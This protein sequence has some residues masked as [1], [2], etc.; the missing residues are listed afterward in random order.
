MN[1]SAGFASPRGMV[2]DGPA[3]GGRLVVSGITAGYGG[4]DALRDVSVEVA[5]GEAVGLLGA[6]GAGKTTLLRA[7]SGEVGVRRGHIEFDGRSTRSLPPNRT[8][9]LGIAHVLQGRHVFPDM[10]VR[11]NL[12]L[13]AVARGRRERSETLEIL[14][15][16][17]PVLAEAAS[18]R[19]GN[20]SGGQQ[21]MLVIG[22]AVMS[23][24]R[25]LLLDEPSLGLA[26]VMF[27]A[28]VAI[29]EWVRNTLGSSILLVEQNSSLALSI[30]SRAYVLAS[31]RL[32]HEGTAEEIRESRILESVYLGGSVRSDRS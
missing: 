27:G 16:H 4:V 26:P 1:N 2:G 15:E 22:R 19:A 25:L 8:L 31:G 6:N 30:V 24:P 12:E 18:Q 3:R 7:I 11:E 32:V 23:R 21:Q 9:R 14:F 5:E 29:V 10:T 17:F 28:I 13:G 20:L